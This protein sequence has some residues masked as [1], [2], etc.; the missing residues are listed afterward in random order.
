[1]VEDLHVIGRPPLIARGDPSVVPLGLRV[2]Y[3]HAGDHPVP[4]GLRPEIDTLDP[5]NFVLDLDALGDHVAV[6]KP[7]GF[8]VDVVVGLLGVLVHRPGAGE[9]YAAGGIQ[10][11]EIRL[12]RVLTRVIARRKLLADQEVDMT[13]RRL[14]RRSSLAWRRRGR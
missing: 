3:F 1:L 7:G 9:R 4:G 12:G 2:A 14:N 5:L 6:T 13:L 8:L 11:P 10:R